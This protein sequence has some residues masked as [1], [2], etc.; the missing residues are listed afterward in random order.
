MGKCFIKS[1]ILGTC[2]PL[3]TYKKELHLEQERKKRKAQASPPHHLLLLLEVMEP[4]S[5]RE[6]R[7]TFQPAL[8]GSPV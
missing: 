2:F 6:R 8:R 5:R 3:I 1:I 4:L 7:A